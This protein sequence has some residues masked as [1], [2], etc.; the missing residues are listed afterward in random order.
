MFIICKIKYKI[1]IN[2]YVCIL[3]LTNTNVKLRKTGCDV[4]QQVQYIYNLTIDNT[5][6]SNVNRFPPVLVSCMRV[7]E[8]QDDCGRKKKKLRTVIP[9][10]PK[11]KERF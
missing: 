11:K 1:K 3:E 4:S 5:I 7:G 9:T 10:E 2:I 6:K 8:K